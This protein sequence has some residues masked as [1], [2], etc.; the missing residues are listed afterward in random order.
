MVVETASFCRHCGASEDSGWSAEREEHSYDEDDFDYNEFLE[1]EFP[2]QVVQRKP[3]FK[4][5]VIVVLLV[6]FAIACLWGF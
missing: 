5:F 6:C 4:K 1:N 2:D 3:D